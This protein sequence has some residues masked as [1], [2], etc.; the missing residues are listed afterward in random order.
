[1]SGSTE[2]TAYNASDRPERREAAMNLVT[3]RRMLPLVQRIVDD[4]LADN[5]N[6]ARLQPEQNRLDEQRRDLRWPER[7]RRYQLREEIVALEGHLRDAIGELHNLS[8]T[9]LDATI[10]RVGFPT[11]VNDRRAFFSWR[12]G[13]EAI[14]SWHFAEET[15]CR[16]IPASWLKVGDISMTGKT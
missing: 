10:G 1:M 15:T 3:A 14:R 16:P 9:L 5:K 4:I 11:I 7:Q 12:P 8:L 2:N 6:L 13:E